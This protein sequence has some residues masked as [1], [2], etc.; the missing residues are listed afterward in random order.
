MHYRTLGNSGVSVTSFTLGTMTFGAESDEAASHAILDDYVAA[1]GNFVDTADVYS[2]GAAEEIV[3]RWLASRPEE[4]RNIVLATKGRFPMGGGPNDV[5]NSRRHLRRA[6][7]ASLR[8]L[9]VEHIDLYQLHAWDPHT[10]L[11]ETLGFL[12]DAVSAGKIGYYGLS[13]FTGWQLTKTV[14]TARAHGWSVPVTLQTQYNLLEREIESEVVPAAEDAGLGLLVWSPL[15]GGWLTGKYNQDDAPAE[16]TRLGDN[17]NRVFQGWHVRGG[18]ER[19]WQVVA[20][21]R[22]IAQERGISPGQVALAWLLE[23]PAVASVILGVRTREQLG[24][25]LAAAAL[26]LTAD[27]EA[28]LVLA[29]APPVGNYPYGPEGSEQRSRLLQG[30]RARK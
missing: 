12:Q 22:Q 7:D 13:N 14:Y 5:G 8:R 21:V 9:G 18:N 4:A 20:A 25:N 24:D 26:R 11:E 28:Q 2:G 19:T 10:P 6:L 27:E 29:S 17:L 16:A 1:G 30:G 23:R 3:G 15:A